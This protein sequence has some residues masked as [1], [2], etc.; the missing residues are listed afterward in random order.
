MSLKI[1]LHWAHIF[2]ASW[3]FFLRFSEVSWLRI[4]EEKFLSEFLM[5]FLAFLKNFSFAKSLN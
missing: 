1:L 3:D 2:K 4:F 5:E